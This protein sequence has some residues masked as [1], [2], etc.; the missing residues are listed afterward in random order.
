MVSLSADEQRH[1][2][3]NAD[4]SAAAAGMQNGTYFQETSHTLLHYWCTLLML[5]EGV[6][7]SG[8]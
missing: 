5:H 7:L 2:V 8:E 4:R 1:L 6:N 3:W